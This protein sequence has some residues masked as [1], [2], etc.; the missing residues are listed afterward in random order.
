MR[1][2]SLSL[3]LSLFISL[4]LSLHLSQDD[5]EID[6]VSAALTKLAVLRSSGKRSVGKRNKWTVSVETSR[7][8]WILQPN[9]DDDVEVRLV[10]THGKTGWINLDHPNYDD[11][12]AGKVDRFHFETNSVGVLQQAWI[13]TG[14]DR[15]ACKHVWVKQVDAETGKTLAD[16]VYQCGWLE[17]ATKKLPFN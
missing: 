9:T 4:S 13:R 1:S 5:D 8:S 17:N 6:T 10:G 14:D 11:F 12:E 3:S 15:W 16:K 2:L 7:S